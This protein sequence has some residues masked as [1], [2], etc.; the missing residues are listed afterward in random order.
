MAFYREQAPYARILGFQKQA[1]PLL[2][3]LN[4]KA[5]I[6]LITSLADAEKTLPESALY[7]LKKDIAASQLY[8]GLTALSNHKTAENEYSIPLVI[9]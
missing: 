9:S 4:E 5:S 3:V 2:K 8:L 1:A 6:P 7:L